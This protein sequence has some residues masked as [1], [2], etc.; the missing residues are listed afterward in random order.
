MN[1]KIGIEREMNAV[2]ILQQFI[3]YFR[4]LMGDAEYEQ[5]KTYIL[6]GKINQ[7]NVVEIRATKVLINN[8]FALINIKKQH[9]VMLPTLLIV[10]MLFLCT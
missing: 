9:V 7:V 6:K 3:I 10:F 5:K 1:K 2:A 8:L 4:C